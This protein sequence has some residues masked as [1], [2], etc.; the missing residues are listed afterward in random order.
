MRPCANGWPFRYTD[1]TA[2][3]CRASTS[4]WNN[5]PSII[6]LRTRGFSTAIRFNACTTSGQFWQESEMY[7]SNS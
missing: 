2:M 1:G 5:A 4:A 6:V 3:I 7:V